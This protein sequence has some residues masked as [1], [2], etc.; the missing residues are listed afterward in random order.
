MAFKLRA[1]WSTLLCLPVIV[2]R[3]DLFV[4]IEAWGHTEALAA[5]LLAEEH[6]GFMVLCL[7]APSSALRRA[8]C[9]TTQYKEG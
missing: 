7:A 9:D 6:A 1:L 2:A 3:A 8:F 5:A 4:A